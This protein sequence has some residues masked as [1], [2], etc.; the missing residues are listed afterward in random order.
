[1]MS[2]VEDEGASSTYES[3]F[4]IKSILGRFEITSELPQCIS[5][6][7]EKSMRSWLREGAGRHLMFLAVDLPVTK[8]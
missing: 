4:S 1:M 3:T 8:L 6:T 2:N 5:G 7:V